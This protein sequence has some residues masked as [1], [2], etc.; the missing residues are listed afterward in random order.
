MEYRP[1]EVVH[2]EHD[3]DI[4][5]INGLK[6]DRQCVNAAKFANNSLGMIRRTFTYNSEDITVQLYKSLVRSINLYSELSSSLKID[7]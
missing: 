6:Y 5:V 1:L 2:D 3:L 7:Y 4:M